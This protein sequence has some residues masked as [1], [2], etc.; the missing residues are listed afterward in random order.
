M[1]G[2]KEIYF[3]G[4]SDRHSF[5]NVHALFFFIGIRSFLSKLNALNFNL[6]R[7]FVQD[8]ALSNIVRI[9]YVRIKEECIFLH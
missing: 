6:V 9:R 4:V 1:L 3:K 8:C 5:G 7:L 2:H